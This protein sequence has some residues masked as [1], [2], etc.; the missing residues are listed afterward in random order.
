MNFEEDDGEATEMA[1]SSTS[2]SSESPSKV[3][4]FLFE[5]QRTRQ[6]GQSELINI[7]QDHQ[8]DHQSTS[9]ATKLFCLGSQ[10]VLL[11]CGLFAVGLVLKLH[12]FA[13]TAD[14]EPNV[15]NVL[16]FAILLLSGGL[17]GAA[18]VV[19]FAAS[20]SKQGANNR[21]VNPA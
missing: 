2:A 15:H 7:S 5:Q 17:T 21:Q 14:N 13:A 20:V 19:F 18:I 9:P 10:L 16:A 4:N 3:G 1:T 6:S 8:S 12:A 11:S